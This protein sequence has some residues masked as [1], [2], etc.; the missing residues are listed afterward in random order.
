MLLNQSQTET[1]EGHFVLKRPPL[2][3]SHIAIYQARRE[4]YDW[5]YFGPVTGSTDWGSCDFVW[6]VIGVQ[7]PYCDARKRDERLLPNLNAKELTR[8]A[9]QD[10]RSVNMSCPM[11]NKPEP[12]YRHL[13]CRLNLI[14]SKPEIV[15]ILGTGLPPE[16]QLKL[17]YPG[18]PGRV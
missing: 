16:V 3:S 4:C 18:Q 8:Y 15:K 1:G 2:P 14:K 5:W 7:G 11:C 17:G 10:V 6:N 13:N 9:K 12:L